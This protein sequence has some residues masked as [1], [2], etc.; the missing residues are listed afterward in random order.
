M[1]RVY[2]AHGLPGLFRGNVAAFWRDAPITGAYFCTYEAVKYGLS[3]DP[4]NPTMLSKLVGG[5]LAGIVCW[6]PTYPFDV[7][8]SQI[9]VL[10]EGTS[11]DEARLSNQMRHWYRREGWRFFVRG[12]GP[13]LVRAVPVNAATLYIYEESLALLHRPEFDFNFDGW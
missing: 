9:Q 2:R 12:L 6:L 8:K 11:Y 3:E 10:P 1:S 5:G 13:T 7:I 4:G